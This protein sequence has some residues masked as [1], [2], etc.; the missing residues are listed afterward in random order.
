MHTNAY[1]RT[2]SFQRIFKSFTM[3]LATF[4]TLAGDKPHQMHGAGDEWN[5][6]EITN[7]IIEYSIPDTF[8]KLHSDVQ[9]NT[10][11]AEMHFLERVSGVPHN[12]PPSHAYWP[13]A[14]DD[15]IEHLKYDK[16]SHTYPERMWPREAGMY[17]PDHEGHIKNRGI[18]FLYGDLN[19]LVALLAEHPYTRQAYLPIWFPEDL[20]AANLGE[21]VPCTL[22]YHF[23]L[24][25]GKL[26]MT[27][28]IRSCDLVRFLRDDVY[29]ACRL[30]QWVLEELKMRR[31][32]TWEGLGFRP[33]PGTLT[34]H[35][36]SL[37]CFEG[38]A[39]NLWR[40]N[41]KSGA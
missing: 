3:K 41:A 13:Y 23:M 12:P 36:V 21:R 10:P 28:F 9:P 33:K 37:H 7:C 19:D 39:A 1:D 24:R 16:F 2:D 20:T 31:Q 17:Y 25:D 40:T 30:V 11:W 15:N 5:P 8:S 38:D 35:I 22:G 4:G 18:R 29:M 6:I 27:Y 26:N 34:M 32:A 14:R